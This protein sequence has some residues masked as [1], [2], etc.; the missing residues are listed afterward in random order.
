MTCQ[1][2]LRRMAV[3]WM[4]PWRFDGAKPGPARDGAQARGRGRQRSI[5]ALF[6]EG[7]PNGAP[8]M[9]A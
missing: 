9:T 7:H 2:F 1:R 8:A 5:G 3:T 4:G 6:H